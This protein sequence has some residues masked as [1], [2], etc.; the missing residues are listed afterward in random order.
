MSKL[1]FTPD[2]SNDYEHLFDTAVINNSHY[3]EVDGYIKKIVANKATYEAVANPLNIPWY[4]VAIVHCMEAGLDFKAHLHNGDPLTQR[5][6]QVPKDR[7]IVGNPPFSWVASATD[8]LTIE[9]FTTWT[10]WSIPGML[11]CFERYNGIGYRLKGINSPYLWSYSNN[12]TSGKYTADGVYDANAVS[13]Q[14]GAAVLLRRMCEQQIV[15]VGDTDRISQIKQ[16]GEQV[17]YNSTSVKSDNAA[18]LQSLLNASGIP[19]KSDGLAGKNTSTAYFQVSG[20]YLNGD[21]RRVYIFVSN[22]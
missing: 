21:P 13:K 20:K 10:D 12:Y 8:A 18:Q 5:T 4:F 16:L 14:C 15:H 1:A 17:A 3:G 6:V 7:P 11:Y 22:Q 2:L 9:G 19:L